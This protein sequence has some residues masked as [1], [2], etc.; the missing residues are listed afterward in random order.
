MGVHPYHHR[1]LEFYSCLTSACRVCAKF[2]MGA[3]ALRRAALFGLL[4]AGAAEAVVA[5]GLQP[6]LTALES[7][8]FH[9]KMS[10]SA[11]SSTGVRRPCCMSGGVFHCRCKACPEMECM[12]AGEYGAIPQ[13]ARNWSETGALLCEVLS[14]EVS[15][16]M[17]A[18]SSAPDLEQRR[19]ILTGSIDCEHAPGSS[20][21]ES[22]P[23]PCRALH[24]QQWP[25]GHLDSEQDPSDAAGR[26]PET[27]VCEDPAS[28]MPAQAASQQQQPPPPCSGSS[29]KCMR[30]GDRDA[31]PCWPHLA[32]EAAGT[33]AARRLDGGRGGKSVPEPPPDFAAAVC[34]TWRALAT[35]PQ[36][37]D[38]DQQGGEPAQFG[39]RYHSLGHPAAFLSCAAPAPVNDDLL[40]ALQQELSGTG[41]FHL[42]ATAS[43][44]HTLLELGR[45]A[46]LCCR[47]ESD[48]AHVH[49]P[50]LI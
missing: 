31:A 2:G 44:S 46:L 48:S 11:S 45:I 12:C 37:R 34:A 29:R 32:P 14:A 22:N 28:S 13:A 49:I 50:L 17:Q 15:E 24:E 16:L 43:Y 47:N 10:Q 5:A 25:W 40:K 39:G 8:R 36:Q 6:F 1:C 20:A 33:A 7:I 9:A 35:D 42:K 18:G 30:V 23:S 21:Q 27:E 41:E 26:R 3:A 19:S 38:G 4:Q